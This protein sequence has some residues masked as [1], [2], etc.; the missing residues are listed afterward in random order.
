MP[1]ISSG[2]GQGKPFTVHRNGLQF[3]ESFVPHDDCHFFLENYPEAGYVHKTGPCLMNRMYIRLVFL[4]KAYVHKTC[5]F[6]LENSDEAYAHHKTG[7]YLKNLMYIRLV[8][9]FPRKIALTIFLLFFKCRCSFSPWKSNLKLFTYDY[10]FFSLEN[11]P[12]AYVH[13]TGP[14]LKNMSGIFSSENYL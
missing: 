11:Y 9:F 7:P 13:K 14:Y 6:F 5:I 10:L 4:H 3:S 1:C 12:R 2:T 8:V